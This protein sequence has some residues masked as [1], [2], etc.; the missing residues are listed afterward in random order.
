M[1]GGGGGTITR[2][3]RVPGEQPTPA[4]D[5]AAASPPLPKPAL[6][7]KQ[8][9]G[10][11][12]GH[13]DDIRPGKR[14]PPSAPARHGP[15]RGGFVCVGVA[16]NPPTWFLNQEHRFGGAPG[17]N[18]VRAWT[19]WPVT[20]APTAAV[21]PLYCA[22]LQRTHRGWESVNSGGRRDGGPSPLPSTPPA[23][24]TQRAGGKV[25][26]PHTPPPPSM[27]RVFSSL[28]GNLRM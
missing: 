18:G 25:R 27:A 13:P 2:S 11:T 12:L 24:R 9:N 10:Y 6:P 4:P 7:C 3:R 15:W 16:A 14:L 21:P 5:F 17:C 23:V 20:P 28:H 19:A 1:R 8:C 26:A 22:A